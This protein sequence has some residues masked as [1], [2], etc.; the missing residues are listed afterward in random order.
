MNDVGPT[1][2]RE[3][4]RAELRQQLSD[5]ATALFLRHGFDAVTVADVARA[6]GVTEKTVFNHYRTKEALLVD[7]WPRILATVVDLVG[8]PGRSP[9]AGVTQTLDV[10]LDALT[11]RGTADR[12]HMA[13][14]REFGAMVAAAETLQDL[15]R[16]SLQQMVQE[17][18]TA[19]SA[20]GDMPTS[21]V[22][23]QMTAVALSGLFHVFYLSLARHLEEPG[24][25][26]AACRRK[27]RADVRR[28]ARLLP[29]SLGG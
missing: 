27:V 1:P 11:E 17:L 6:C 8:D 28:A 3:R 23:L 10:E 14:V 26:A 4:R 13:R 24:A 12:G 9:A 19:L 29:S 15:R 18:Q 22:D 21:Q 2:F 16:R 5:T 20:R 7:R 25:D